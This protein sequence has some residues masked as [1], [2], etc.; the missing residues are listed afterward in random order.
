MNQLNA[1]ARTPGKPSVG[2]RFLLGMAG[3]VLATDVWAGIAQWSSTNLQLLYGDTH[4]SIFFNED[5][6]KLD[7]VDDVR[8]VITWEHVNG[9]KYGD[10]F[11]FVDITNAD[12]TNET[13]TSY[14]GE[15]SPRLSF[16]KMAGVDLNKGLLNDVLLT[17]TAELGEGFRAFLYGVAVDLNLPGFAFFQ[18]NYYV[19]NDVEVFG[20]PSPNDTGSQITLVWLVPFTVANTSWAFEGFFDYAFDVS[21]AEDN[22]ITAPR[23]LLDVGEFF[24]EKGAVQAGF[25]YQIWRNKF[26]V[27][28]IDE[29]V[30]QAMVKFIF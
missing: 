14:Y 8:S 30:L 25:E 19:R 16:G 7:S 5:T 27:D 11:M 24:G 2:A 12:R 10:N 26:G 15:I 17:T 9:W 21:P 4:Q 22:I 3:A 13:A 6:G 28:G 1:R 23:L 29:D 20:G 18:F